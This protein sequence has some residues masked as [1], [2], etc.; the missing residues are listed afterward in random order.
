MGSMGI[1][2]NLVYS[3]QNS[4]GDYIILCFGLFVIL[5]ILLFAIE[6]KC[7][8]HENFHDRREFLYVAK[9]VKF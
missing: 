9:I 8:K 1:I 7:R 3:I 6:Y 5:I 4:I 2:S